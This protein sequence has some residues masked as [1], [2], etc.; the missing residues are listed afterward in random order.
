MLPRHYASAELRDNRF[1]SPLVSLFRPLGIRDEM[2]RALH[3]SSDSWERAGRA[4][5]A[6]HLRTTVTGLAGIL[7]RHIPHYTHISRLSTAMSRATQRRMPAP[8][9]VDRDA[10]KAHAITHGI[11]EAARAFELSEDTV[12][13]WARREQWLA[14]ARAPIAAPRPLPLSIRPVPRAPDAPTASEAARKTLDGMSRE[15]RL[16]MAKTVHKGFRE[17]SQMSGE[18]VIACADKLKSLGSLGQIAH[19]DWRDQQ[20]KASVNLSFTMHCGAAEPER[21]IDV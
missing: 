19:E 15:S 17:A 13:A 6:Q 11:R 9:A 21:V 20:G 2:S 12:K 8:L 18:K 4:Y 10:V 1:S 14:P 3:P 16:N 7:D 5:P